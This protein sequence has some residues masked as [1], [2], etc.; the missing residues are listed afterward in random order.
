M[1]APV[2]WLREYVEIDL[3]L[4]EVAHRLTM[5]GTE[6]GAIE[7][8]GSEWGPVVVGHAVEVNPHPNADRLKLVTV[9]YGGD[10]GPAEVVCGAPNIT[11]GQKIAYAGL[12]ATLVDAYKG[13]TSKLKRSKIRGVVSNGM[14]CSER[15]LGLSDE[16]EGILVLPDDAPVGTPLADY[17]GEAVFDL[18]LT[19]NRPDCLSVLGVAREVAALTDKSITEP[20]LTYAEEG[21]PVDSLASVRIADPDLCG[22]YTA[23][24]LQNL[25][26]G[27]SPEW[28]QKRLAEQGQ[29]SINNVVDITNYVMF[30]IGQPLHAF[31]LDAVKDHQIIVRRAI[32]GEHLTT[33]DGEDRELS[34][35]FLVIADPE[36]AIGLAGVM[37]GANTEISDATVSVLLESANFNGSNNRATAASLGMKTEAT[38]RFEKGL[39]P[40]LAEVALRRAT[41]LILDICGGTVAQGILDAFPNRDEPDRTVMLTKEKLRRVMGVDYTEEQVSNALTSLGFGIEI[42]AGGYEVKPPYWRPDVAIPEDVA[43]EISRIIGY[44]EVPIGMMSGVLPAWAPHRDRDLR[45]RVRDA[46]ASQGMQEI[47]SYPTTTPEAQAR[48]GVSGGPTLLKLQNPISNDQAYLRTTLRVSILQAIARNS[49]TWRGSIALFELGAEYRY[50]GEGLPHERQT[51]VGGLAG[52]RSA[53]SGWENATQAVDFFDAK[54][55]VEGML[56]ALAVKAEFSPYEDATFAPGRCAAITVNGARIGVLGEVAADVLEAVDCDRSPVPMF[57]IDIEALEKAAGDLF[58]PV[59][60]LPY[61]RYPES[62][63]DLAIVIDE[64]V[65]AADVIEIISKNRLATRAYI[66]SVYSGEGVVAGRKSLAVRVHYQSEKKTLTAEEISKAEQSILKTLGRQLNAELRA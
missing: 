19:P 33:L 6:V 58:A 20:G 35:E 60:Y 53:S 22:R 8:T 13:G 57:E 61:G 36:K 30:E 16:H 55:V 37:G 56:A 21:Q 45:E 5:A 42:T 14:V 48:V 12:G 63:R 29:A 32:E 39:R 4:E 41:K 34:G 24:V 38:L 27:P 47:I 2:S 10:D 9:E 25:K 66:V 11:A 26:P 31:D 15:E 40:G 23:T 1:K 54:G 17:L 65:E 28:L 44:D 46:L 62:V 59:P 18:E 64:A 3:P 51:V 43:E 7:Q 49:H 50:H 52:D